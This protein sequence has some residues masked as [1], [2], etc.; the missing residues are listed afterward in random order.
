M[1]RDVLADCPALIAF[2]LK[3]AVRPHPS[4][5]HWSEYMNDCEE[6]HTAMVTWRREKE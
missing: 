5:H 3:W 1:K 2:K 6:L 4:S